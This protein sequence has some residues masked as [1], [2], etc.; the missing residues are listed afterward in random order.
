[1]SLFIFW[2]MVPTKVFFSFSSRIR[3]MDELREKSVFSE[4]IGGQRQ[5]ENPETD[6]DEPSIDTGLIGDDNV[7]DV[8]VNTQS[9]QLFQHWKV[10]AS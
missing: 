8:E 3:R 10:P 9:T 2:S 5:Q 7:D 4:L 1:M 6:D